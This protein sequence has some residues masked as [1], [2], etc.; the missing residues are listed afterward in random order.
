MSEGRRAKLLVGKP[1]L[2]GHDVGAKVVARAL[3]DA[4]FEVIYSG[5]HQS[6]EAIAAAARDEDV[7][8]IGLSVLSGSHVPLEA[9]QAFERDSRCRASWFAL[10]VMQRRKRSTVIRT[11]FLRNSTSKRSS[12]SHVMQVL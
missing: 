12:S 7:D 6:P 4:G 8:V 1:G 11:R 3:A 2:D 9:S 10:Q 5:L